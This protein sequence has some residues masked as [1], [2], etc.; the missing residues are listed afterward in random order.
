[1]DKYLLQP[2][3]IEFLTNELN[4]LS[5]SNLLKLADNCYV[6]ILTLSQ[7]AKNLESKKLKKITQII[8]TV[9][10]PSYLDFTKGFDGFEEQIAEISDT[11]IAGKNIIKKY[12]S[13]EQ[14]L[15]NISFIGIEKQAKKLSSNIE[16]ATDKVFENNKYVL[17]PQIGECED[18]LSKYS[19]AKHTILCGSGS[20]ALILALLAI[21]VVPGDE[22]IVPA[23]SFIAT[24]TTAK[25]LGCEIKFADNDIKTYTILP[26]SI[27][28]LIT[29]KTRAIIPVG[30]YGQ[31]ADL[32]AINQ[33]AQKYSEKYGRKIYVIEDAAQNFGGRYKNKRSCSLTDMAATSFFPAK[34]LGAYGDA[35]AVFTN[36]ENLSNKLRALSVHGQY[37]RY[38]H[39]YVGI[40]G[41]CDTIQATIINEKLKIFDA[42][43]ASRNKAADLYNKNLINLPLTTPYIADQ[44]ISTYAQYSIVLDN[45]DL[46]EGLITHLKKYNIPAAVHY[47]VPLNKQPCFA[48]YGYNDL[49]ISNANFIADRILSLPMNA[50]I[51]PAEISFITDKIKDFF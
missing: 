33:I 51:T 4:N 26:E 32:D 35:G 9:K 8:T 7:A 28:Q 27:E 50:Y 40:N 6:S 30:L 42:E 36:D 2:D 14:K 20:D 17:G 1:M 49:N 37:E 31:S 47:P 39:E 43:I 24:A 29:E 22:V 5:D 3:A 18:N 46:R 34:P 21:D 12:L 13:L 41:R 38:V 25:I 48:K 45:P 11:K 23:L 44:N 10:I 16:R 15:E 19:Q